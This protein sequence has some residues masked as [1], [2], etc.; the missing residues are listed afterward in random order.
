M[1]LL[2]CVVFC[3]F[4]GHSVLENFVFKRI[5]VLLL[6]LYGYFFNA[7]FVLLNTA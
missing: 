7:V 6:V 5:I 2:L 1:P 4:G 3:L